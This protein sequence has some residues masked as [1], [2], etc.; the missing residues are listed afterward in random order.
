MMV[1]R[2]K[3]GA[4]TE[5]VARRLLGAPSGLDPETGQVRFG[6][7]AV[8]VKTGRFYDFEDETSG[9]H[10]ELIQRFKNLQNGQA[11]KWLKENITDATP[12]PLPAELIPERA[13]LGMLAMQ[14]AL[15]AAIEEEV[16]IDSFAEPIHKQLFAAIAEY[17]GERDK[18]VA[19]QFLIDAGGGDPLLPVF[20][21]YPLARYVGTLIVDAPMAPD[22]AHLAR[23]LAAQIRTLANRDGDVED[24]YD[25]EPEPTPFVSRFGGIAFE[26]LDEPGPEH[27]HVIDGL[28]TVGDKSVLGG[29]SQSGKSFLAIHMGMC[30][31]TGTSFF[32][33]KIMTPGL[34]IYQA[35]EGGRGIKKR[36]RAW[37]QYF[38]IKKDQRVPIYILQSKIDIHSHE[39][40][41]AGLIDE[42]KG[43]ERLY[44][45]PAIGLFIDTLQKAQGMAD[46]NSGRDMG[47]VMANVDRISDAIPGCH[48]CLVHHMNANGTKLRGH[49]SV[50]AG[51]DQVMLVVKDVENRF[52]TMTLDKQKDDEDGAKILF[53]LMQIEIGRRA[54]DGKPITS[55]VTLPIGGKIEAK[56][57]GKAK[58]RTISLTSQQKNIL[59]ALKDAL[60]E[61]GEP[62]PEKLKLPRAI[63]TVVQYKHWRDAYAAIAADA[64]EASIKKAMTRAGERLYAL[65]IIGKVNP[66]VWLTG[67]ATVETPLEMARGDF[68]SADAVPEQEEFPEG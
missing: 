28:I 4:L 7:I 20:E 59:T 31:A 3:E 47:T 46:E 44:N 15:M 8:N 9:T 5:R 66:Y 57:E 61:H 55:C 54:V 38:G 56:L 43:I 6:D 40:D 1:L 50:Y 23:T 24:E 34:V 10:I 53:E 18:P 29:A 32:G 16:T 14:P 30:I 64:E 12:E 41:T 62:T 45:M 17:P 51:V 42:I 60:A 19:P 21:G 25:L 27:A 37:R 39:G 13:L 35:G 63:T 26:Q 33:H 49:T 36:F 11:E 2:T 58:D 68:G 65:G 22:A 67:R 48:V 52:S